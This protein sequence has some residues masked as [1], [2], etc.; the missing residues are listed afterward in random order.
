M[1]KLKEG[2]IY[3]GVNG[4]TGFSIYTGAALFYGDNL[5]PAL[6]AGL[7][8]GMLAFGSYLVRETDGVNL[9]I[10]DSV[11]LNPKDRASEAGKRLTT[12]MVPRCVRRHGLFH[13]MY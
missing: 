2:L 3:A 12:W 1:S 11:P 7:G 10:Q 5:Q 4:L 6:V 13:F 8:V 9:D